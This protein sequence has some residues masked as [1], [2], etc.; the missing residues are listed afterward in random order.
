MVVVLMGVSG[1]GKTT[2]G[3]I[4]AAKSNWSFIEGDDFH[5]AENVE[6]MNAGIPLNDEDRRPW[7]RTSDGKLAMFT[8][9]LDLKDLLSEAEHA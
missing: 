7:P 4:L 2:I 9:R 6:K 3:K 5:P 1:T 8:Q